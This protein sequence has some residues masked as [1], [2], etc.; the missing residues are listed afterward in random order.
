MDILVFYLHLSWERKA[1]QIKLQTRQTIVSNRIPKTNCNNTSSLIFIKKN[2][3]VTVMLR[4]TIVLEIAFVNLPLQI[5][6]QRKFV[7]CTLYFR[8]KLPQCYL[9]HFVAEGSQEAH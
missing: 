5:Y 4:D 6:W 3:S 2:S 7:T 8:A 1:A 9:L